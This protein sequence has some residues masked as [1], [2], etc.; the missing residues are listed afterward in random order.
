VIDQQLRD[1]LFGGLAQPASAP[2]Q[3]HALAMEEEEVV[4]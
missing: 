4:A 1:K 2:Q 3:D